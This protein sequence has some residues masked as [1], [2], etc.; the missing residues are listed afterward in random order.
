VATAV[1]ESASAAVC[2]HV[3]TAQI[4][5]ASRKH[6]DSEHIVSFTSDVAQFETSTSR[7]S[8]QAG[9]ASN[10]PA[11]A[12]FLPPVYPR[13]QLELRSRG[14]TLLTSNVH[15]LLDYVREPIWLSMAIENP[16]Y[17]QYTQ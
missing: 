2:M 14:L 12:S 15:F 1:D 6:E 9:P 10:L 8:K 11:V 5:L 3:M 17:I 16:S 7:P 13:R 4:H